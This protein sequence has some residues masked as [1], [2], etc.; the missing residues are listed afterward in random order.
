MSWVGENERR[1]RRRCRLVAGP[2]IHYTHYLYTRRIHLAT[3]KFLLQSNVWKLSLCFRRLIFII[4]LSNGF[5]FSYV[6]IFY[7]WYRRRNLYRRVSFMCIVYRR[8]YMILLPA[9]LLGRLVGGSGNLF[10]KYIYIIYYDAAADECE[11]CIR[12]YLPYAIE[13]LS[14]LASPT[15]LSRLVPLANYKHISSTC[16]PRSQRFLVV[17]RRKRRRRKRI[18]TS[19]LCTHIFMFNG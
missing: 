18:I 6:Y 19:I 11:V 1:R 14:S 3:A 10:I 12:I 13:S 16:P 9:Y 15:T 7:T 5:F 8:V 17:R 4:L 2:N